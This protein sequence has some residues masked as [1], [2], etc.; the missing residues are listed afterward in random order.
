MGVAVP[1][2][3]RERWALAVLAVLVCVLALPQVRN[4]RDHNYDSGGHSLRQ[5]TLWSPYYRITLLEVP[6]PQG[7]PRPP[8]YLVDVNHDYHQKILDLSPEFMARNFPGAELNREG[9]A[10]YTLPYRFVPHPARILVVGAGTGNDVAAALRNGATHVDAVEIDPLL[11]RLGRKYHPEHPYDSPRVSV[12]VN[13]AR[14]FFKR[15]Q[16]KYDLIVFGFL[17]SHTMFSSLSVLR[18]DDY[19]YTM[20]SFREAKSLL[21]SNGTAVLAFDSGRTSFITDRI[22]FTLTRAF[23]K[24]PTAYYTG[25][26]GAGVV[27]VEGN[28]NESKV[29]EYPEI[30][31]ELKSHEASAIVSTDHWPFLYLES[32]TIPIPVI[33]L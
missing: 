4:L 32:R 21:A 30:S 19:V 20:E 29:G 14:A 16:Q 22:F 27:F 25:Y 6:P 15:T 33:G 11:V 12:F 26:D 5:H 10:A 3:F 13:D 7:W 31:N 2:F 28:G 9:L 23:G 18:L 24:A 17:D 8:A 1:F